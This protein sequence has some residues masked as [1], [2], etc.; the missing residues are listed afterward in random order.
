[1]RFGKHAP[2][3]DYRTLLFPNYAA[4]LPTPAIEHNTLD[5]V[6]AKLGTNDVGKL[7]PMDGN[8][9]EGCCTIA[10]VAHAKT[11]FSGLIGKHVVPTATSVHKTYRH[12][13]GGEDTGLNM[14]D[15]MNHWH[16][17]TTEG[18]KIP[19]FAKLEPKNHVHVKQ[20]ISMFGCVDIGFQV[21]EN[22]ISDFDAKKVWTPGKLTQD[23]HCVLAVAYD[24]D[25]VT[26]LTW[27]GIQ[28]GTWDWW[29]ACCDEAY[30]VLPPEAKKAGFAPGFDFATLE[31]DLAAL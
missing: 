11:V 25:T 22:C 9:V 26:V 15:V 31:A 4:T 28:K 7:F 30:I 10:A 17:T 24:A 14:L 2:K 23:G 8:N 19:A 1:M 5:A 6:F 29:D 3:N 12:L 20:A 18:D 27:G 16:N 13:T 21:Q